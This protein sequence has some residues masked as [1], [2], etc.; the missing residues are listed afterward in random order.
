MPHVP[1][2]PCREATAGCPN[3]RPCPDHPNT[4]WAGRPG[5][6]RQ[7]GKS[8]WDIQRRNARILREHDGICHVCHL[9]GATAVDHVIPLAEGGAD[10][11]ANLRPIHPTPCHARKSASEATRARQRRAR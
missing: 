1:P 10:T 6:A 9:P 8:G 3:L 2:G 4:P 5:R 7:A 11:P